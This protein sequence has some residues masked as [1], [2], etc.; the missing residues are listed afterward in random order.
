MLVISGSV[1][2]GGNESD[3]QGKSSSARKSKRK[4]LTKSEKHDYLA[5]LDDA[6]KQQ[7]LEIQDFE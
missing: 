6:T 5:Q 2:G 1:A 4:T 3:A 7:V